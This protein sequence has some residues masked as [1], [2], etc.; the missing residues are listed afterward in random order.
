MAVSEA[1]RPLADKGLSLN[2]VVLACRDHSPAPASERYHVATNHR[3][4]LTLHR[5]FDVRSSLC[6]RCRRRAL[7]SGSTIND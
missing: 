3:F 5:Q 2:A 4:I 7:G 1:A 6:E